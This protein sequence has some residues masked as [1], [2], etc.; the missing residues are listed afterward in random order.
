MNPGLVKQVS[1]SISKFE[2]LAADDRVLVA[3]SGGPDS[4]C[5]LHLLAQMAGDNHWSLG[6]AHLNHHLRGDQSDQEQAF[7]TTLAKSLGLEVYIRDVDIAR[8]AKRNGES[9]E[10]CARFERYQ[11]FQEMSESK[12]Y[13]KIALAHTRDDHIET[14]MFRLLRGTGLRGLIGISPKRPVRRGSATEVIRPLIQN[15][16]S[17]V[18]EYLKSNNLDY[19]IDISNYLQQADRNK[20]RHHLLPYLTHEFNANIYEALQNLSAIATEGYDI[21]VREFNPEEWI[22]TED[23]VF[24]FDRKAAIDFSYFQRMLLLEMGIELITGEQVT[25]NREVLQ[26][27]DQLI[28]DDIGPSGF[29]IVGGLGVWREYDNIV[30]GRRMQPEEP[31]PAIAITIP[32]KTEL[33]EYNVIIQ[34]KEST[35]DA[36]QFESFKKS[37]T[38]SEEFFDADSF[39]QGLKVRNWQQ[40]DSFQPLG[41]KG[42]KKLQD[43]FVDAKLPRRL[44]GQVPLLVCGEQIAWVVGQRIAHPFR[45]Q[46][47]TKRVYQVTVE[48]I[49]EKS[50]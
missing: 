25:L 4:V 2:L 34:I 6:V 7:V 18:I 16:R 45:V 26:R 43:Y 42:T 24:H 3:V 28:K 49:S 44:R 40:G 36:K 12:N 29:D 13:N 39:D 20:I 27:L 31:L 35:F 37:K 5:M 10:T 23:Q 33:P 14:L 30:A 38:Q 47:S 11:F 15:Q 17:E 22:E 19:R 41:L 9:V 32:G 46:K 21:V 8:I 1:L 48:E 50:K